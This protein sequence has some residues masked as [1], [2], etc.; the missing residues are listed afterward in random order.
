MEQQRTP[1]NF[2]ELNKSQ[3]YSDS[4]LNLSDNVEEE[5][6][7]TRRF[8]RK[9]DHEHS[10]CLEN[11][12]SQMKLMFTSFQD[13]QN[14]KFDLLNQSLQVIKELHSELKRSVE[15]VTAKYDESLSKIEQLQQENKT[16]RKQISILEQKLEYYEKASKATTLEIRNIP[17]TEPETKQQLMGMVMELGAAIQLNLN[18]NTS[19]IRNIYRTKG[20]T[21]AVVVDFTTVARKSDIIGAVIK[22][23]KS[24][25]L[26]KGL[27]LNTNDIKI[28]GVPQN[29]YISDFLTVKT[30]QLFYLS[31]Q[32]TKRQG[33]HGCWISFGKI[34]I[35]RSEGD[36]PIHIKNSEDLDKII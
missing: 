30:Q 20:K 11:F 17:K 7:V 21:E 25:K 35:R 27:P 18:V 34:Y 5:V 28:K 19:E 32:L 13:Q 23:N 33:F 8:K 14:Q 22:Y 36:S 10:E 6:N 15:F 3:S 26:K 9:H 16:S 2:V 4:A 12:T 24:Q 29:I 1:P 31:R